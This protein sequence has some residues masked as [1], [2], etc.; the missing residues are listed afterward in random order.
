[1]AIADTLKRQAMQRAQPWGGYTDDA[2]RRAAMAGLYVPGIGDDGSPIDPGSTSTAVPFDLAGMRQRFAALPGA[3]CLMGYDKSPGSDWPDLIG[4]D[5]ME[6]ADDANFNGK[7]VRFDGVDDYWT[8]PG[9]AGWQTGFAAASPSL[10]FKTHGIT[11]TCI[12][13][14]Q[15]GDLGNRTLCHWFNGGEDHDFCRWMLRF[16]AAPSGA[17][18]LQF[19]NAYGSGGPSGIGDS[20]SPYLDPAAGLFGTG[21][22]LNP[23]VTDRFFTISQVDL[24]P[25]LADGRWHLFQFSRGTDAGGPA[26]EGKLLYIDGLRAYKSAT[27]N[28]INGFTDF[29]CPITVGKT[30]ATTIAE[31]EEVE[32]RNFKGDMG[33]FGVRNR[34][35]TETEMQQVWAGAQGQ[36]ALIRRRRRRRGDQW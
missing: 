26:P 7:F 11:I 24:R 15:P 21:T 1:M 36:A 33:M 25:I 5:D 3:R 4:G 9:A 28:G 8:T 35:T 16:Y 23:A 32:W 30:E 12:M 6:A 34:W 13:R 2:Y 22:L 18:Y 29:V 17:V 27:G 14:V 31:D 19:W 20:A 10:S